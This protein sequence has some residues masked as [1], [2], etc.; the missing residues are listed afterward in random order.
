[1]ILE[2]LKLKSLAA[3][4]LITRGEAAM[5][6]RYQRKEKL[7]N[8]IKAVQSAAA[9]T[10]TIEDIQ[11]MLERNSGALVLQID[12]KEVSIAPAA[13]KPAATTKRAGEAIVSAGYTTLTETVVTE[14]GTEA[15]AAV[16]E[17]ILETIVVP[18]PTAELLEDISGAFSELTFTVEEVDEIIASLSQPKTTVQSV[19][20]NLPDFNS[21]MT[22]AKIS[23]CRPDETEPVLTGTFISSSIFSGCGDPDCDA[24]GEGGEDE[25]GSII[26]HYLADEGE[27]RSISTIE[28]EPGLIATLAL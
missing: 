5:I 4:H 9:P 14:D 7:E 13:A 10:L 21:T 18:E 20:D 2:F 25:D 11:S 19:V 15:E 22:L 16:A 28:L 1:M 27:D 3:S 17:T 24:C 8:Q 23:I 26:L 6:K 12:G